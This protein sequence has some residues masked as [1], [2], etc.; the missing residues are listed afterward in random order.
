MGPTCFTLFFPAA[1]APSLPKDIARAKMA[2]NPPIIKPRIIVPSHVADGYPAAM[3]DAAILR[4][5]ALRVNSFTAARLQSDASITLVP[6]PA[7]TQYSSNRAKQE[8]Q[9]RG[10]R[11]G[12]RLFHAERQ[13]LP[14]QHAVAEPVRR[15]HHRRGALC[16]LSRHAFSVDRRASLQHARRALLPRPRALL[17]RG[18]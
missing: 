3:I 13:S 10:E 2:Q 1:D 12:L 4:C 9:E 8:T 7:A 14:G 16:R 15:R 17:R 11:R 5:N 18:Q 6:E